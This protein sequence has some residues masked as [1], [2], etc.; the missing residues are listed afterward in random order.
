MHPYTNATRTCLHSSPT[1]SPGFA[2][3]KWVCA[4][5]TC[6][7][8][9]HATGDEIGIVQHSCELGFNSCT[10][11]S[12]GTLSILTCGQKKHAIEVLAR[13]LTAVVFLR[14]MWMSMFGRSRVYTSKLNFNACHTLK[15]RQER[16]LTKG[17]F[18]ARP[19]PPPTNEIQG[20]RER[21]RRERRK[22]DDIA[23]KK[24]QY[25]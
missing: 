10:C 13:I 23:G 19:P 9:H 24:H 17:L 11:I 8:L 20:F 15:M 16:F 21:R 14:C 6:V 4:K 2:S 5:M 18:F 22:I 25:P 1:C 7:E 12:S 3:C